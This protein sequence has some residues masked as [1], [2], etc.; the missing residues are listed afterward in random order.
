MDPRID[1]TTSKTDQRINAILTEVK[2]WERMPNRREPLTIDMITYQQ[3]QRDDATPHSEAAA[4]YD[5]EVVGIFTGNR[6][7]EWAQRDGTN[8][9]TVVVRN[10]DGTSKAFIIDDVEFYSAGRRRMTRAQALARPYLVE[11]ADIRWRFQ[12]NGNNGEKKTI[13]RIADKPGLCPVSAIL[14]IV[15]RWRDLK[16]P[17]D[18]PLA[19]FTDD[20]LATGTAQFITEKHINAALQ[21]AAREVYNITKPDELARFTSH[22]IRVGAC[23][24]LHAADI[25]TL[26]SSMLF[27]GDQIHFGTTFGTYHAKPSVLLAPLLHSTPLA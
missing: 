8:D 13:V 25:S 16:L 1:I 12:K 5:W 22:S 20:G 15:Q 7:S 24:S 10:I 2:R 6:L 11:T 18:H 9:L 14:R 3:L 23:V 27:A 19:V 26:K 17:A 21:T 4:I